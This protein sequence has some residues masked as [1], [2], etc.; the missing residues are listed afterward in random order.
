MIQVS[1]TRKKYCVFGL[2]IASDFILDELLPDEGM[3][4]A[5]IEI[6]NG[7]VPEE[8]ND[9][10]EKNAVFQASRREF[11]LNIQGVAKFLISDG[12]RIIVE[13]YPDASY[14]SVKLYLLGSAFGSLLLLRG[15]LPIH[16]SAALIEGQCVLITGISGAGKSTLSLALREKGYL[17]LTDDVA[18]LQ[19][20]DG[21]VW[22]QPGYP[23]QKIWADSAASMGISVDSLTQVSLSRGDKYFLP[24]RD[25]FHPLPVR[26][27]SIYELKP[28]ERDAVKIRQ[29]EGSH[30]L[31]VLMKHTY[32]VELLHYFGLEL[33]HF[34]QCAA[35]ADKI[36]VYQ[37]MR[38]V[39]TFTT[40][41]QIE[42]IKNE[43]GRQK[44]DAEKDE[45]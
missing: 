24:A 25:G 16:G 23:Q 31:S 14:S 9:P 19:V 2:H 32:R 6:T 8:I 4:E 30:K 22:V 44:T 38:P 41:E 33:A 5:E 17:F 10:I 34:Q 1:S 36:H 7:I 20:K 35:A 18:V 26:L 21:A 37:L 15:L 42:I 40:E 27:S 3:A 45:P 43:L 29:L 12:K 13:P 39:N 28:E 11:L